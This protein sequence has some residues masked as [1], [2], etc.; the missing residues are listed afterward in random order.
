VRGKTKIADPHNALFGNESIIATIMNTIL[1]G[2]SR[3]A[4]CLAG[5][6]SVS[7]GTRAGRSLG[8]AVIAAGSL[9]TLWAI[10]AFAD[11]EVDGG[12]AAGIPEAPAPPAEVDGAV[13]IDSGAVI[14]APD[15]KIE[16][17]DEKKEEMIEDGGAEESFGGG[18]E[19]ENFGGGGGEEEESFGGGGEDFSGGGGTGEID[20]SGGS[21]SDLFPP[22]A[23]ELIEDGAE[24]V[25]VASEV[26][27]KN[28]A[29]AHARFLD[30]LESEKRFPSAATCAQCHPDHY[31]EW[32]VSAH[33]YAQ[34]S[35]VFNAFQA[36]LFK[37]TSGT[38]GDFCIRCH[39]QIG[40]Q[41]EEPI[42][43][44]NLKRHPAS[45]EGITCV[46]CHRVDRNYGK[47]S[48]RT[49]VLEGDLFQP[50]YGPKGNAILKEM[51]A[52]NSNL[53]SSEE[54]DGQMKVHGDVKKFD[55]IS[56]SAFCGTC[57]DVNLLNGFRLEEAFTQFK[58]SPAAKDGETCQDCHMGKIP[59]KKSADGE[60][61]FGHG[62][63][64]R[65]GGGVWVKEGDPGYGTTTTP[66]K[67]TNHMF[68]GPDY[69]IV[70]PGMFPHSKAL[71]DK[72][73]E[74]Q[75]QEVKD[76][77]TEVAERAGLAHMLDFKW[78]D[79]WGDAESAFEKK[80]REDEKAEMALPWPWDD[81]QNRADFRLLLNDQFRLLNQISVERH[82][83]LR[84]GFQLGKTEVTR[85][86]S[87]GLDF[88]IQVKNGTDG[89]GVPTGFDAERLIYLDVK[90]KDA[91]GRVIYQSGDRDPNGD[92]RDLHSSYVHHNA[93]K[94]APY[95]QQTAW[96][97][98]AGLERMAYDTKWK[99]DK[100]L[101][102]LQS[103]FI[104]RNLRGGER[105]QVLAVNHSLDPLPYIRPDTRP[106]IL[107]ARPG[108]ARKQ[109]RI[110]APND[111]RWAD[112]N[113]PAEAL[114]GARP[115][116]VE[117][118]FI[119]QMVPVNLIKTI[120]IVG[121]DYNLSPKEVAKRVAFGHRVSPSQRDED[122][123]GGAMVLWDKKFVIDGNRTEWDF[124][125]TEG[126]IMAAGVVPF[127]YDAKFEEKQA[128]MGGGGII[129]LS[130][131]SLV[132]EDVLMEVEG[133]ESFG[134]EPVEESFG[135]D[136]A[137]PKEEMKEEEDPPSGETPDAG[138]EPAPIEP[139]TPPVTAVSPAPESGKG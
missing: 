132:P 80:V 86:D 107:V 51:L 59:G 63:A 78:E 101:F 47:V 42:F 40:M 41:R 50:V 89:H 12:A 102:N 9:S 57:H 82:Q 27:F 135:D 123:R 65:I 87:K 130:P 109:A 120:S 77:K 103:K 127:P 36:A 44:S 38:N 97:D 33:A 16:A 76:G 26:T 2:L 23:S 70:H 88:R 48:G 110:L 18:G 24:D 108:A 29:E 75:R 34:V 116:T 39:T 90:V 74:W 30:L 14:D 96:K 73:W 136:P 62:P 85:D 138:D 15:E 37:L 95:L 1:S 28:A 5:R 119:S 56:T 53:K 121:F 22:G 54:D 45:L 32:S 117:A 46:V 131:D 124:S 105:E 52:T 69:S 64:A 115:Y 92:V 19:E 81:R 133:E 72:L 122:R 93:D 43:T 6:F 67:R 128:E 61:N 31:R 104:T 134:D 4:R 8:V 10:S 58:N 11:D 137:T 55:P 91:K 125:P 83:V 129:E 7:C 66:R 35:P 111:S 60:A 84:R 106:G 139:A 71:R 13:T 21:A 25:A 94:S 126:E 3:R 112:Y 68:A 100:D 98:A 113:V 17:S 114:T 118:K 20:F 99:E 79:G 49:A